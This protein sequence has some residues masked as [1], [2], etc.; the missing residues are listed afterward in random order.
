MSRYTD[1]PTRLDPSR[2]RALLFLTGLALAKPVGAIQPLP[3][4]LPSPSAASELKPYDMI[5]PPVAG[6][7]RHVRLFFTYDCPYCR[8][9]HNG[10]VQWGQSL[11]KPLQFT[12]VP[13]ITSPENDN[14][15]LAVY[16]RLIA[17]ILDPKVLP[18]YDLAI[19][20][21]LQGDTLG[22]SAGVGELTTSHV[23]SALVESGLAADR[24][25]GFLESEEMD[26]LESRIPNHAKVI[27]TYQIKATP[28][29]V[30]SGRFAVNPDHTNG[31][32]SQFL[33]LLNGIVSRAIEAG[34]RHG[35][36]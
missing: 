10:L 1:A 27:S 22:Q 5:D 28:T 29:V 11:P 36:A 32:T 16:G 13:I 15:T 9:Y 4:D 3:R 2:R 33:T 14:Q 31:N 23:L 21:L 30:V 18:R 17:Q 34:G 35:A 26:A 8:Q 25:T 20:S 7:A 24:I 12:V 6:D 19:F